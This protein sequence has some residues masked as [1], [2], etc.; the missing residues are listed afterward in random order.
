[1]NSL[2][3][4]ENTAFLISQKALVVEDNKI[5]VLESNTDAQG[6]QSQWELPGGLLETD[7]SL[8]VGLLRE[9]REETGLLIAIGKIVAVWDHWE[10]GFEFRN[11]R[12]SDVRIIGIAFQCQRICGDIKLSHEHRHYRWVSITNLEDMDFAPN[13]RAAIEKYVSENAA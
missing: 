3:L 13:S 11:G 7:E 4:R 12:V 5:L 8:P 2:K 9:V 6:G 10:Y 1:M